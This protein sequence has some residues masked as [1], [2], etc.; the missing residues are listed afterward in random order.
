MAS[1]MLGDSILHNDAL[2]DKNAGERR[3]LKVTKT[4]VA[5]RVH[6][7]ARAVHAPAIIFGR[8]QLALYLYFTNTLW[9]ALGRSIINNASCA[10]NLERWKR[11]RRNMMSALAVARYSIV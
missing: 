2:H 1:A 11:E 8:R 10:I 5:E 6:S 3:L 7:L 9:P 4:K